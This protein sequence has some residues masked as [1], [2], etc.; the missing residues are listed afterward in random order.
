MKSQKQMNVSP[1][2]MTYN[3]NHLFHFTSFSSSI[4]II[5]SNSLIF[6]DFKNMND[7]SESRREIFDEAAIAELNKYKSLSFTLDKCGKRGFEIDSLWGYYAEKGNGACLV[8]NKKKLISQFRLID[9]FKRC[10]KI[11]YIKNFS[12]A[13]FFQEGDIAVQKQIEKNY[14][15]IFF[16]KSKDWC[17]ENEY[18]LLIRSDFDYKT[19]LHFEDAL[20]AIIICMP[21]EKNIKNSCEYKILRDITTLPILHYQTRLGDKILT[22]IGGPILWPLLGVDMHVDV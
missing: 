8:F 16:T 5:S 3:G 6:G 4:R 7:I 13:F 17:N 14:K 21:L 1:N 10:G 20:V 19:L 15:E 12:N 2:Y 18:R 22:E 11:R 9:G